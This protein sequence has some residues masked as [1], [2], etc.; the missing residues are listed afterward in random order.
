MFVVLVTGGR[1][2]DTFFEPDTSI[3]EYL[4]MRPPTEARGSSGGASKISLSFY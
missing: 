3:S 2:P 4:D 1:L